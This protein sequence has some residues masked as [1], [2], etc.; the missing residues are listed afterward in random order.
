MN[1]LRALFYAALLFVGSS[2]AALA[3]TPVEIT[4]ENVEAWADEAFSTAFDDQLF[5]GAAV[6]V[7][8][9]GEL[10]FS[11]GYG[12]ADY[13]EK[14]PMD[15]Q[16][17]LV[18][19][20]STT[21]LFVA[22]ALMQ[23]VEQGLVA[24]LDDPA[25][26]YLKRIQLPDGETGPVTLRDLTTHRGGF[27][28]SF[29]SAGTTKFV[30]TPTEAKTVQR[31]IPEMVRSPGALSVYSNANTAL[32]GVL[33]EDVTGVPLRTYLKA[34]VLDPLGMKRSQLN[35]N[36][37]APKGSARSHV[38]YRDGSVRKLP[39]VAKHP[40]YAPSGG[41]FSTTEEMALF[42]A[43]HLDAGRASQAP[44][45]SPES[46]ELMHTPATR[47]HPGLGAIGVQFFIEDLNGRRV[48][49]HG[50]GLPG[51]TSHVT[52][53]PDVNAGMFVSVISAS[54]P[55]GEIKKF[56]RQFKKPD[57]TKAAI[58]PNRAAKFYWSFLD[59]FVGFPEPE[60]LESA[61][62]GFSD[63]A[64]RYKVERR[65]HSNILL[66][67]EL[68]SPASFMLDV[69]PHKEGGLALNGSAPYLP[70]A[71]N[72]FQRGKH[73]ARI[74]AFTLGDKGE[75]ARIF[76]ST[77][78]AH[79]RVSFWRDSFFKRNVLNWSL[80]VLTTSLFMGVGAAAGRRAPVIGRVS[81][82]VLL[83][84][85][86]TIVIAL[87]AGYSFGK[88]IEHYVNEGGV[89]RLWAIA[90]SANIMAA[91]AIAIAGTAVGVL[92]APGAGLRLIARTHASALIGAAA[93]LVYTLGSVNLL[94]F[95]LP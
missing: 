74:Y 15:P 29:F 12:Y 39:L 44:I 62:H 14:T 51:F 26:R 30:E 36:P 84:S 3:Q 92:R 90:A 13:S 58:S 45:L 32:Q 2:P 75:P 4:E 8:K 93:A 57:A 70:I 63:Y 27:E 56:L 65:T 7:V 87:T 1:N 71:E 31:I 42:V 10:I 21:K 9:D 86:V 35:D 59:R 69:K 38:R 88:N 76:R 41:L 6:A 80:V 78:Q 16:D 11:R 89:L 64:G 43:A 40:V 20:C 34:H 55:V 82:V 24:S 50:C 19:V 83:L 73:P 60:F 25:N 95:Q 68:I 61:A 52:M 66:G 81:V 49:N 22:T 18:R 37:P 77:A 91:A 48:V 79:T 23:L 53:L 33:I 85:A 54:E 5:S 28:D 72:V 47:N 46:F 94:G 17:T 67:L